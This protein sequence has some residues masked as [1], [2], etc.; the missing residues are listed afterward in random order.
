[1][2]SIAV[3]RSPG[4]V[5][6]IVGHCAVGVIVKVGRK[7][8][9]ERPVS[10]IDPRPEPS[11]GIHRVKGAHRRHLARRVVILLVARGQVVGKNA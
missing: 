2:I 4:G 10:R 9:R 3:F 11:V 8:V 6:A 1:V 7:A 5:V